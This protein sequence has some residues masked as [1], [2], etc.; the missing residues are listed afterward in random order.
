[1]SG[2]H[3][4]QA[5]SRYKAI[6]KH[7]CHQSGEVEQIMTIGEERSVARA[8]RALEL[9]ADQLCKINKFLQS[10]SE[11]HSITDCDTKATE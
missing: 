1:M 8:V 11:G 9:I 2:R 4:N 3:N 10:S 6:S 5:T 7:S